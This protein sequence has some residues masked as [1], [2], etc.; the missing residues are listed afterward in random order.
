MSE[1]T[2]VYATQIGNYTNGRIRFGTIDPSTNTING[3]QIENGSPDLSDPH[4][5]SLHTTGKFGG[6]TTFK[7][8]GIFQIECGSR[9]VDN[10]GFLVHSVNG[11]VVIGSPSG[12]VRIFGETVDIIAKG[13]SNKTGNVNIVGT[14]KIKLDARKVDVK[15]SASVTVASSGST[16]ISASN[17]LY[18]SASFIKSG[19]SGILGGVG[20]LPRVLTNTGPN[21]L[22]KTVQKL[23]NI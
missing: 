13:N 14:Q 8:P 6:G 17:I 23:F 3:V 11:D 1:A 2:N 16:F 4:Y 18:L 19:T 12:R 22:I 9:S 7:S 5:M 10:V 21:E 20:G 15:G